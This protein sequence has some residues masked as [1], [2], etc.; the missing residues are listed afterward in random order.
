MR[1]FCVVALTISLAM[2]VEAQVSGRVNDSS[3]HPLPN[4]LVRVWG[5]AALIDEQVTD[6][7]G[8][9]S[10]SADSASIRRLS[11]HLVG[12][13]SQI[14]HDVF[15]SDVVV[16]LNPDPVVLTGIEVDAVSDICSAPASLQADSIWRT[17]ASRYAS[18]T[19]L[20]SR[21]YHLVSLTDL[22][23]IRQFNDSVLSMRA[24]RTMVDS[25]DSIDDPRL[26]RRLR[27][28]GYTA[29]NADRAAP[30][31]WLTYPQLHGRYA[32]H[33]ATQLFAEG[34]TFRVAGETAR[35][36]DLAFCPVRGQ[37]GMRGI[38]SV[39]GG[40]IDA[41]TWEFIDED[42]FPTGYGG[43]AALRAIP[44]PTRLPHLLPASGVRWREAPMR[45]G[46][47]EVVST[48]YAGWRVGPNDAHWVRLPPSND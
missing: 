35:G 34:H 17:A 36:A 39:R 8:S 42:G 24:R 21:T 29:G 27:Q 31:M 48:R 15:G 28:R 11:F 18:N 4:V 7:S 1:P 16:T 45:P 26:E 13:P 38:L 5:T 43:E 41:A 12:A 47:F 14:R 37:P 6:E 46:L 20:L 40:L 10:S 44:G 19:A 3:G 33:F 2:P 9:Y 32:Y 23:L 25:R 30:T 22:S